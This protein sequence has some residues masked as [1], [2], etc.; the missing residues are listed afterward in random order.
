MLR[1]LVTACSWIFAFSIWSRDWP[2]GRDHL[3]ASYHSLLLLCP[4]IFE[5][6][7]PLLNFVLLG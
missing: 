1:Y 4:L 5:F 3:S 2:K 6:F 7:P